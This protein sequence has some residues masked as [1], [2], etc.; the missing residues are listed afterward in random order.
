MTWNP[1]LSQAVPAP[2][3][4]ASWTAFRSSGG[5]RSE[6]TWRSLREDVDG[7]DGG[8]G[9]VL[10][11][12]CGGRVALAALDVAASWALS[13]AAGAC[14]LYVRPCDVC[15]GGHYYVETPHEARAIAEAG[16]RR[17]RARGVTT[18]STVVGAE[19]RLL[20]AAIVHYAAATDARGIVLG[21]RAHGL[22]HSM[23]VGSTSWAVARRADRPVILVKVSREAKHPKQA[24]PGWLTDP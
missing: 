11:P 15:R 18:C 13:H 14:V 23:L 4:L 2:W 17:L 1:A 24:V 8:Q 19:R 3:S 22:L 16:A 5:D 7:D 12:F 9:R 6:P 10:V 21:T 20:S